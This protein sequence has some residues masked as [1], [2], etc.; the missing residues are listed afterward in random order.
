MGLTYREVQGDGGSDVSGQLARQQSRL[1]RRLSTIRHKLA[2]TSGKG[3][4]GKSSLTVNLAAALAAEGQRVGIL[5]ADIHGSTIAKMMG[6]GDF[7][8]NWLPDGV[9]PARSASGIKVMAIDF[10]LQ[11][12]EPLK[13]QGPE[14]DRFAWRGILEAQALREFLTDTRWGDLDWLLIDLP[15]GTNQMDTLCELVP[16]LAGAIAVTIPSDISRYVVQRSNRFLS[17]KPDLDLLGVAV[18]MDGYYHVERNEIL[19]LFPEWDDTLEVILRVPFDPRMAAAC[20]Q[21]L[22]YLEHYPEAE[23][24]K[25]IQ[26]LA[27]QLIEPEASPQTQ[28]SSNPDS[29]VEP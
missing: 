23:P 19:P 1:G 14:S 27:R 13:W 8:P 15:P 11:P 20:D 9:D 26:A 25:R 12:G 18:N 22:I 10:L 5:D 29:G 7:R 28:P 21:G 4:V 24:A 3:G 17:Q 16:E 6:L 2:I